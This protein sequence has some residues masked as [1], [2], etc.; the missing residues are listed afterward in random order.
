MPAV[1]GQAAL[2]LI[3]RGTSAKAPAQQNSALPPYLLRRIHNL[4]CLV[5]W[6][7]NEL[8]LSSASGIAIELPYTPCSIFITVRRYIELHL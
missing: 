2:T 4:F 3:P 1:L 8:L 6:T 7:L 5:A